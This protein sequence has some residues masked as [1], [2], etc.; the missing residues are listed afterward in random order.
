MDRADATGFGVSAGRAMPPCSPPCRSPSSTAASR[1]PVPPPMEVSFVDEVGAD[2]RRAAA[3]RPARRRPAR[4][5]DLG[6]VED[7]APAPAPAPVQREPL[8]PAEVAPP[9]AS[10]DASARRRRRPAGAAGRRHR[11]AHH[12][13]SRPRRPRSCTASATIR[14]ATSAR[15]PATMTGEARASVRSLIARAADAL[16]AATSPHGAE[17]ERHQGQFSGHAQ[18]RR[19][20]RGMAACSC[21]VVNRGPEPRALRAAHARSAR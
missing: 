2:L 11:Q 12:P 16:P 8:P 15:P 19:F 14:V 6:P 3:H 1:P 7:A 13:P 5:P 10:A 18:P 17:A 4:A 20:A 9:A 21:S